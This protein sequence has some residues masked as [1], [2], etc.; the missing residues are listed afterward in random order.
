MYKQEKAYYKRAFFVALIMSAVMFLPFVIIDRGYFVFYGDYNAQQIPFF[1]MCV[2][3]VHDGLQGWDWHTDLGANFVGSYTYYTLGSPFFWFMCL[4]PAS[5]S[6]YLMAP[7]LC[8]KIALFSLFA[9]MYIRRFVT[10]PQTALIGGIL[11]A[12]SSFNLYNIFFQFQDSI[13]WF[14]LLLIGLEEAVVNKR[15]AVFALAVA[16]NALANYF[17]F[18]GECVFLVIYFLTRYAMDKRFVIGAKGFLCLAFESVAGVLIAGVLFI[19]SI[20]Q[21]LD[22]PRSTNMLTDWSFLFYGN[23]Q[24]YGLILESMFFP[25]EIAARNSMFTEANAKWSSVA[26]YLPLFG[27]AGVFAFV[28]GAKGHWARALLP[29]C[30]LFAFVP[31]LNASFTMFN[32]NF[33]TRWF[34]M[35]E[36]ICC[37]ATVYTLEHEELDLNLG[38]KACAV[39]AAVMGILAVLAPFTQKYTNSEGM[40]DSMLVL[41]MM[42]TGDKKMNPG[43]WAALFIAAAFLVMLWLVI[44]MRKKSSWEVYMQRVT[45]ITIFC[46]MVL[47]YYFI[48]YGR[49]IG[50]KVGRYN[51]MVSAEFNIDDPDFYRIEGID[52]TNNVNMLWGM[53]SLKSFTSIVPG[54]TFDFYDLTGYNRTVNSAPDIDKYA[55]RALTRVKYVMIPRDMS[56][57]SREANLEN[58]GIYEYMNT[59]GFYDVYKTDYALPMGFA[60]D[61]YFLEEEARGNRKVDNLMVRCAV[62]TE[63]Q[64]A[65]YSDILSHDLESAWDISLE[66]FKEDALAR[67]ESGVEDFT[68]TKQGFT[69]RSSYDSEKLVVFS[70]PWCKGWSATVNGSPAEI[71][72]INGGLCGIRVPAGVCEISFT[73]ETPGLKYGVIAT[74]AGV[75]LLALYFVIFIV[76]R[77]EKGFSYV[78]L[79]DQNQVDGVKAHNS[80]I[81]QLTRSIY[82]APGRDT[83]SEDDEIKSPEKNG[84]NDNTEE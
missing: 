49:I 26:L 6:E 46:S 10:K 2:Q 16:L 54:S 1:K 9:F 23:E 25:P 63:E 14:P 38:M 64:E 36:L 20:Y 58:L 4:F 77:R 62:L 43:V 35:P 83:K 69:A 32:N 66:R 3:A 74:A 80:Y 72:K 21:V 52:E 48:G 47:G 81:N 13:I 40:E 55:L 67:I 57:S 76:I 19:P 78:H 45:A 24:R 79:Y 61:S 59:Q 41:R 31:G 22:V 12:F 82:N 28:K 29:I 56:D 68:I 8:V 53:S 84:Q 73:Y 34:Y 39:C 44:R 15:H 71:D 30:L 11:Y 18:I 5:I 7:L 37:L 27:M 42:L 70:V 65:K 60:Y 17:F 75:L 33:Y 50:P 51:K